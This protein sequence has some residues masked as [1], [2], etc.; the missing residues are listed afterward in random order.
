MGKKWVARLAPVWSVA[1]GWAA[2]DQIVKVW[3]LGALWAAEREI[4]PGV[5]WF[6]LARNS[7]AA[8]GL[9]PRGQFLFILV[10]LLLIGV[11]IWAPLVMG[12]RRW[13]VGRI[14]L[15][16]LVG[17]GIGNLIDRV[18]R[19]GEVVDFIDFRFWPVFNVA[20]TGIVAGTTL[21]FLYLITSLLRPGEAKPE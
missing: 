14:G 13:S 6:N 12:G 4:I 3:A 21:V 15:G 16:L 18:F 7:G 1:L 20:D 11:G 8:F 19:G 17:G 5:L 9:F 10:A 2:I